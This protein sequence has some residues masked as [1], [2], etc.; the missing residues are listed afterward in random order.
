[1]SR[2]KIGQ[3]HKRQAEI[4]GKLRCRRC[5]FFGD[6]KVPIGDDG[7]CLWCRLALQD[8]VPADFYESGAWR[9]V[10]AWRGDESPLDRLREQLWAEKLRRGH[11]WIQIADA[12]GVIYSSLMSFMVSCQREMPTNLARGFAR[13]LDVPVEQILELYSH[14]NLP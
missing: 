6:E 3:A 7:L 14:D 12:M 13:Y 11:T 2:G 10:V 4:E 8:I 9:E 1:M 5:R